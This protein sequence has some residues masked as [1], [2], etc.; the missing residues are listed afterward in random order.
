ME[1]TSKYVYRK[2]N[3]NKFKIWKVVH[4]DNGGYTE[5]ELEIEF[6]INWFKIR[7]GDN[8][9]YLNN[10]QFEWLKN[11]IAERDSLLKNIDNSE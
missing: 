8:W 4:N 2:L 10:Y 7:D 3:D 9:I 6:D 5:N 11:V 1:E